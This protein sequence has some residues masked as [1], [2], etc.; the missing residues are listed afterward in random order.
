M[1]HV[2]ESIDDQINRRNDMR[3]KEETR[4]VS[5]EISIRRKIRQFDSI[6]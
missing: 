4:L 1:R 2:Q 5:F 3:H 6:S